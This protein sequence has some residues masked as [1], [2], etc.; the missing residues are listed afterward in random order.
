MR[1][2][3]PTGFV[4]YIQ[5]ANDNLTEAHQYAEKCGGQ[6]LE[7]TGRVNGHN[8]YL[9]SCENGAHPLEWCP[10]YHHTTERNVCYIFEDLL[11]KKFPPCRPNFLDGM[12]LDGYN[13]SCTTD[14]LVKIVRQ[15][16]NDWRS[17]IKIID[18]ALCEQKFIVFDLTVPREYLHRVRLGWDEVL[19]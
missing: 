13:E 12:H 15:Y 5:I 10:L 1:K 16:A 7:R 17:V 4:H 3:H 11:G 18:K 14:E 8:I 6:C 19:E 2:Y 9:W